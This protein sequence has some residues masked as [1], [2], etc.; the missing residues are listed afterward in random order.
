[1]GDMEHRLI[2]L[3][4]AVKTKMD[5]GVMGTTFV[6]YLK[7]IPFPEIAAVLACIYTG[8]RIIELIVG[9]LRKPG[10]DDK[11]RFTK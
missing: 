3:S 4:D 10:R 11:G 1:M 5:V 8:L 6:G 2:P 7:A 9:W